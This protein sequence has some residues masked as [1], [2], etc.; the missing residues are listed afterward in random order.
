MRRT[1]LHSGDSIA[2]VQRGDARDAK[3]CI[4]FSALNPDRVQNDGVAGFAED[5][6]MSRNIPAIHFVARQNH[7]WHTPEMAQCVEVAASIVA[8]AKRRVGYGSSM[9]GHGCLRFGDALQLDA[10]AA[11]SPQYSIDPKKVPW[12]RR[13]AKR[14]EGIQLVPAE[15]SASSC[16][17]TLIFCDPL[18]P[19]AR[20]ARLICNE[21][22]ARIIEVADCG[23][24]AMRHLNARQK[25]AP[26]ILA[27]I[28][29]PIDA[30][31]LQADI[32]NLPT[33]PLAS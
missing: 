32:A 3:I 7:W 27:L 14:R 8:Q 17:E 1:I 20:H 22:P 24:F 23:H 2:L 30:D 4:T 21:V 18:G 13:W 11:F 28:E 9:G 29:G 16:K 5:F 31:R 33:A 12:E 10:I 25:L 26:I 15:L 19:D 6:L